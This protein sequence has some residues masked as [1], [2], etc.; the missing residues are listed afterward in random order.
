MAALRMRSISS[1]FGSEPG[2]RSQRETV[3]WLTPAT[4]ANGACLSWKIR[5]RMY[6]T[7]FMMM[8]H[9]HMNRNPS[10]DYSRTYWIDAMR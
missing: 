5:V 2:S 10:S 4:S 1:R 7:A 6:S 9:A 3:G 8:H